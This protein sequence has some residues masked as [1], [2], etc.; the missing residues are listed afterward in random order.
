MRWH[1]Y[2]LGAAALAFPCISGCA[3]FPQDETTAQALAGQLPAL[4]TSG[5]SL[6][7]LVALTRQGLGTEALIGKIRQSRAYYRL[8]A[9]DILTLRERGLPIAVIDYILIA[10]RQFLVRGDTT[11]PV[12]NQQVPEA[13][14]RRA[15]PAL[16]LGV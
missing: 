6:D 12:K 3:T 16:Y 11:T 5:L 10:E 1:C 8:S 7:D 9:A 13:V 4:P 14:P 15:I 2:L